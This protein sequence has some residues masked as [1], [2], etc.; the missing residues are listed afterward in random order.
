MPRPANARRASPASQVPVW[1]PRSTPYDFLRIDR[2]L[3]ENRA[4]MG[5]QYA[6]DELQQ[7]TRYPSADT[8]GKK[9]GSN[10]TLKCT[11]VLIGS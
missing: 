4:R 9:Q 10:V 6:N 7:T 2:D 5:A 3:F 11:K 1:P 8:S